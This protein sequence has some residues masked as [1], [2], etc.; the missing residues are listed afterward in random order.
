MDSTTLLHASD[1]GMYQTTLPYIQKDSESKKK[2]AHVTGRGGPKGSKTSGIL[3]FLDN[4]F[5]D[6]G[7]SLLSVEWH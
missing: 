6:G 4:R 1:G 3:H 5:T 2:N 7:E